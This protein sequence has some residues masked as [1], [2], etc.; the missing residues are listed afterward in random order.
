MR[1][2]N[3]INQSDLEDLKKQNNHLE[4]QI[5][6]LER[7]KSTGNFSSSAEILTDNGLMGEGGTLAANGDLGSAASGAS[8]SIAPGQSLLLTSPDNGT[9]PPKKKMK[10]WKN[11]FL[12]MII[13][14]PLF[15]SISSPFYHD[16]PWSV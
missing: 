2:K 11:Q 3:S 5:R 16:D 4:A 13:K 6:A 8:K 9:D 1:R 15:L 7:A 10:Q 14:T 12:K